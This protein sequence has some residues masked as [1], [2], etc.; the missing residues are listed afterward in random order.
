M[1]AEEVRRIMAAFDVF[2]NALLSHGYTSYLRDYR[3]VI[4]VHVGPAEPGTYVYLF[5]YCIEAHVS[6]SLPAAVYRQSLDDRLIGDARSATEGY[7]WGVNWSLL[8]PGWRLVVP[9]A[10]ARQWT[11]RLGI[12]F[13]EM[14]IETN[15]QRIALIFSGL[16]VTR[17][18]DHLDPG[19]VRDEGPV[20]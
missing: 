3:L 9:S 6:T 1:E 4:D 18:A 17:L 12:P 11:E 19:G 13:H 10:T 16:V 20:A 8:Y 2:D 5:R 14:H 15:V 7:V